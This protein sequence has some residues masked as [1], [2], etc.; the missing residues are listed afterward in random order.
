MDIGAG[1]GGGALLQSATIHPSAGVDRV[2]EVMLVTPT[3]PMS[4]EPP[5]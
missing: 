3:A 2:E 1:G 4:E 5:A